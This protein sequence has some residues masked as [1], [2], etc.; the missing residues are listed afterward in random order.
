[1][2]CRVELMM[3]LHYA[4]TPLPYARHEPQHRYS[5]VVKAVQKAW[6]A[7]GFIVLAD[8]HDKLEYGSDYVGTEALRVWTEAMC[9]VPEPVLKWEIPR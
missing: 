9:Q 3:A 1:M 8:E 4:C 6:L 5:P 2:T 7:K